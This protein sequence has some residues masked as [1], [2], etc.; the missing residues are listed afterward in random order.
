MRLEL[1]RPVVV[2]SA[3]EGGGS[4]RVEA[5][6]AQAEEL[7]VLSHEV[8]ALRRGNPKPR[9]DWADRALLAALARLL[10]RK[11][12]AHRLVTP[13]TLPRW[14][15]RLVTRK[16][17]YP[18]RVGRPPIDETITAL[19]ERLAPWWPEAVGE[20]SRIEVAAA[21]ELSPQHTGVRVQRMKAWLETARPV[22]R[23]L[24]ATPLCPGLQQ[25]TGNWNRL[26]SALWRKRIARH[27]RECVACSGHQYGLVPDEGRLV[28]LVPVAAALTGTGAMA[29]LYGV[30]DHVEPT[31]YAA[32]GDPTA[33]TAQGGTATTPGTGEDT[34]ALRAVHGAD[35][36]RRHSRRAAERS[37]H[38]R[39]AQVRI[40][41]QRRTA[42]TP[43]TPRPSR[44]WPSSTRSEP[45]PA[46]V[47]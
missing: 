21:L 12:R 26:P 17:T 19:I 29:A 39:R 46:A 14:H 27:A 36:H 9:L 10:P 4:V 6:D 25:V 18:H 34:A 15:R 1:G 5:R 33:V 45:R 42:P 11:L 47:P 7:L 23:A 31:A 2:E 28:G 37:R 20:L 32:H 13:G 24:S 8:A 44:S 38:G 16:W 3:D 41:R 35:S 30:A 22:V 40:R 43:R